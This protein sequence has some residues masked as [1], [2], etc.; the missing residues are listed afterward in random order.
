MSPPSHRHIWGE[1]VLLGIPRSL[2]AEGQPRERSKAGIRPVSEGEAFQKER[3]KGLE[4]GGSRQG[5]VDSAWRRAC[6]R[7]G[8]EAALSLLPN[9]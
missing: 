8:G 3:N 9:S 7:V 2:K 1:M 5:P 6:P 4:G